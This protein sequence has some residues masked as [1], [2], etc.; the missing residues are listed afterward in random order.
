MSLFISTAL[1]ESTYE[2]VEAAAATV[3]TAAAK[4]DPTWLQSA[5]KKFG[6]TPATVWIVVAALVA[7][8]AVLLAAAKSAKK[9]NA[10]MLAYA[11]LAIALSF[12]LS[13]VRL[14]K[15]PTHGAITPGSMLPLMLFS[16]AF[17]FA[18]GMLA[19]AVYGLL[20]FF[21]DPWVFNTPEF[22]LDW[23]L[24]FAALGLAGIAKGKTK[25]WLIGGISLAVVGRAVCAILA[26]I[27][28]VADYA[29]EDLVI[30][31][32]SLGSPLLYSAVYNGIYL[33]PEMVICILLAL[34]VGER[35]LKE[36]KRVR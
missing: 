7:L 24:A 16:A 4:A 19:G 27:I 11:A 5:V 18:P 32:M 21:Q 25:G 9:W 31:G 28:I 35:L 10:R 34:L 30:N 13:C 14:Y 8:G 29:P 36:M 12:V 3:E 22:I 2:A 1:A 20:Q 6:E 23:I 15:M 33:I 26:G 17:G